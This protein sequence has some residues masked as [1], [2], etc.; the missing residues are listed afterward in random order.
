MGR[1]VRRRETRLLQSCAALL[2][3]GLVGRWI[4][5]VRL[6]QPRQVEFAAEGLSA[7]ARAGRALRQYLDGR[8]IRSAQS[9][10]AQAPSW[11]G[12]EAAC[13]LAA[14]IGGELQGRQRTA[15]RN[16][17]DQRVIQEGL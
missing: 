3:A 4:D 9:A 13:V 6:R 2:F 8:E 17:G 10:G 15:R 1:A 14:D 5:A 16:C 11:W 7:G 12:D